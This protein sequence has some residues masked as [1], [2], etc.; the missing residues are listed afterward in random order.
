MKALRIAALYH[1]GG[2]GKTPNNPALPLIHYR[3]S[4]PKPDEVDED[5]ARA[6]I[7]RVSLPVRDPVYGRDGPLLA[8]WRSKAR[9]PR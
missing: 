9:K 4:E 3:T 7:S 2:G 5:G 1:F 8:S 6:A